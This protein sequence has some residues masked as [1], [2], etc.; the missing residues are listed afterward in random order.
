MAT[1]RNFQIETPYWKYMSVGIA[2]DK[3]GDENHI[4][5]LYK[6]KFGNRR[7]P[8]VY[9]AT[10]E[11]LMACPISYVKNGTKLRQIPISSLHVI[12]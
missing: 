8:H 4:E 7:F 2:E 3:I 6:D 12:G 5:I 1:I 9:M 11:E 10:R